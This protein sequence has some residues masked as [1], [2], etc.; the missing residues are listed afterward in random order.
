M[1]VG[2]SGGGE[3]ALEGWKDSKNSPYLCDLP[4]PKIVCQDRHQDAYLCSYRT[5]SKDYCPEHD[6]AL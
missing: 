3:E 1:G 6:Y 4:V 2:G 5:G